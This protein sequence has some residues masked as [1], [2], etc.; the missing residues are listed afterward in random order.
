MSLIVRLKN[1]SFSN[2]RLP[3]INPNALLEVE[4]GAIMHYQLQTSGKY[5]DNLAGSSYVL[6]E[7][8]NAPTF[9]SDG[10]EVDNDASLDTGLDLSGNATVCVVF[11]FVEASVMAGGY[12]G[13]NSGGSSIFSGSSGTHKMTCNGGLFSGST[14]IVFSSSPTGFIF[15]A[16]SVGSVNKALFYVANAVAQGAPANTATDAT[17]TDW[18]DGSASSLYIGGKALNSGTFADSVN[19]AEMIVF[20]S[21]KTEAEM[22]AIYHRSKSRMAQ[23]GITLAL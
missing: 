13:S 22:E 21:E 11:E 16:L 19:V 12:K 9:N 5:Y 3:Q 10:I 15:A 18:S 14:D 6:S 8:D 7:T 17:P 1:Q 20:Q 23:R 2:S 4:T